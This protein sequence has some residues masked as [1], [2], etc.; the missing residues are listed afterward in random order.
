MCLGFL[1][2]TPYYVQNAFYSSKDNDEK[3][4]N[5]WGFG[6]IAWFRSIKS[7]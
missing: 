5:S 7:F 2:S 6:K 3:G 1:L 4:Q